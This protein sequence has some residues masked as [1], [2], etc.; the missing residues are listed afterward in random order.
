MPESTAWVLMLDR[1]LLAAVGERELVH[2]IEMPVLLD[3]PRSPLYCRQVLVWN[4]T[5]LPAM[6]LAAWLREEPTQSQQTLAG[7]VAYQTQPE[8]DPAFGALLLAGI[9]ERVRVADDQACAL[10]AQPPNWQ[11]LAISCFRQGEQPIPILD[12]PHIFG[13]GLW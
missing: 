3:V 1:H 4:D 8:A 6:D 2:L 12:L 10:P 13:G 11:M 5:V 7:V 9:P